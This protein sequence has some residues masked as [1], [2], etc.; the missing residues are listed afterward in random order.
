MEP[1]QE[2]TPVVAVIEPKKYRINSNY[3]QDLSTRL[4]LQEEELFVAATAGEIHLYDTLTLEKLHVF[5]I[6]N[7]ESQD[8]P[9][10]MKKVKKS[11]TTLLVLFYPS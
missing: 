1:N 9:L 5:S 3:L 7:L 8:R 11:A 10:V 4:F 2:R 6:K